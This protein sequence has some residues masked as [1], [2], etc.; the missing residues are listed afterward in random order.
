M[1]SVIFHHSNN[2]LSS[3]GGRRIDLDT[4]YVL[5]IKN[6]VQTPDKLESSNIPNYYST[7]CQLQYWYLSGRAPARK[8]GVCGLDPSS[9]TTSSLKYVN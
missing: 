9:G 7:Q 4:S 1:K 3:I 8:T 2:A 6:S 5:E